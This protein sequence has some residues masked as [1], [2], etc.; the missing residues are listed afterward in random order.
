MRTGTR[1]RVAS[2]RPRGA[3]GGGEGTTAPIHPAGSGPGLPL[4][5]STTHHN[6]F[7][8][9]STFLLLEMVFAR[10]LSKIVGL[11]FYISTD[12]GKFVGMKVCQV[13]YRGKC[14]DWIF[15][16]DEVI[17]IRLLFSFSINNNR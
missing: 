10:F 17:L 9:R 1:R 15:V 6:A 16:V 5:R 13:L 14:I 3:G 11:C 4:F 12:F 7:S 8:G 2:S